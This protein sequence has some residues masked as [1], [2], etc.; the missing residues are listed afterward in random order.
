AVSSITRV[1]ASPT[2]AASEQFSVT[3]SKNVSG[4]SSSNFTLVAGGGLGGTPAITGVTGSGTSWTVTAST[5]TGDG[6]LGL[7]LVNSTGVADVA[8][9]AVSN[10]PV[11]SAAYTLDR[12]APTVASISRV[13]ASPTNAVSVQFA[14]T[15]SESITGLNAGN[16]SLVTSGL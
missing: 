14:V 2:N 5:G 1:T 6:T 3:F 13:T 12:T 9:N 4:L 8:G 16:F 15:F 10:V 11:T 7:S